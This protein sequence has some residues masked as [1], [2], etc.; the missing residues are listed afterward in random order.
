VEDFNPGSRKQIAE[1]LIEKG[2][3]PS[4]FT[5]K[6]SVIVDEE[7]LEEIIERYSK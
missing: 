3:K 5:E 4:K 1:R 6:G 2:W 7:V